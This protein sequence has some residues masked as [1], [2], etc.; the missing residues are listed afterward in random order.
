MTN[1]ARGPTATP[2]VTQDLEVQYFWANRERFIGWNADVDD[3]FY[4]E[5][6]IAQSFEALGNGTIDQDE[7]LSLDH[8]WGIDSTGRLSHGGTGEIIFGGLT[9][10]AVPGDC[11]GDGVVDA[12]DLAC[13]ETIE[14]RDVILGALNALPG[15][16]DGK[17]GVAFADFLTLSGN[18]GKDPASYVDGNVDL[19]EGVAFADFLALSGNFGKTPAA[20]ASVPEPSGIFLAGFCCLGLLNLRRRI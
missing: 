8:D 15:D 4:T 5:E 7:L 19:A 3:G 2:V 10:V 17:D 13:V 14:D 12:S 18:F 1:L 9:T 16:L 11:N 6:E 20:A